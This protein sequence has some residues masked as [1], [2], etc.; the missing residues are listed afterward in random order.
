MAQ[1]LGSNIAAINCGGIMSANT[2]PLVNTATQVVTGM[3]A[4]SQ[5]GMAITSNTTLSTDLNLQLTINE[6]GRYKIDGYMPFY[7]TTNSSNGNVKI[8]L[9]GTATVNNLSLITQT[10]NAAAGILGSVSANSATGGNTGL[11]AA[12]VNVQ[13]AFIG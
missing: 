13:I 5:S 7:C 12:N 1:L 3:Y 10:A 9:G 4:I 6:T 11:A 2:S 8:T